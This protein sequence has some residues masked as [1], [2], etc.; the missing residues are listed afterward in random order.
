[1]PQL[2][3]RLSIFCDYIDHQIVRPVTH[4]GSHATSDVR[5]LTQHDRL[6]P[7]R[8]PAPVLFRRTIISRLT[9]WFGTAAS[10]RTRANIKK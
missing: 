10:S 9:G 4:D 5:Y 6:V 7:D 3:F 2:C 1:L 8:R